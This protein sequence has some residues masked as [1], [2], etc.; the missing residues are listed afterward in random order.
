[1]PT[2]AF[3]TLR[4]RRFGLLDFGGD[5]VPLI[6]LHGTFGRA[7]TF[8]ATAS[9]LAPEFRIIALD[10]R[11]HGRS[12][13]GGDLG[14]DAF[15]DDALALL[16]HLDQGPALLLGHSMGGVVAYRLAA[17][18]PD[19]VRALVIE[20]VGSV[21]DASELEHP[22]FDVTDWPS[23]FPDR[24]ALADFLV[25]QGVPALGYFMDSAHE[26]AGRWRL[27]FDHEDMMA[28]QHG[29]AGDFR[30]DWAASAHPTLLL[31]GGNSPLLSRERA[32]EMVRAR[33][34]TRLRELAGCGHWVHLDDPR[35]HAEQVRT[36]LHEVLD[37]PL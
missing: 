27:R 11:G 18:R 3:L 13:H 19:L 35:G 9:Y 16:E 12:D 31:R 10:Q 6:A 23:S 20:D 17:R 36:F 32:E 34:G 28:V 5:G 30:A 1:M 4:G 24:N 8:S 22:V 33:P 26:H 2:P 21:T 37:T 14:S 15:V 29:N 25:G 7:S